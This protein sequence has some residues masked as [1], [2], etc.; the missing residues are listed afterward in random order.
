M[1]KLIYQIT[2]LI[3]RQAARQVTRQATPQVTPQATPQAYLND[4][5]PTARLVINLAEE[6]TTD[7]TQEKIVTNIYFF[8]YKNRDDEHRGK[9]H[10]T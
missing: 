10:T 4:L 6:S 8:C 9:H 1:R 7:E 2:L 5:D 3:T